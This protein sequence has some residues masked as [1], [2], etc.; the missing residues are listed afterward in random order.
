MVRPTQVKDRDHSSV[1]PPAPF[2]AVR[3]LAAVLVA[4]D[5]LTADV[6]LSPGDPA[7]I[8]ELHAGS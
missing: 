6:A 3:C 4:Y 7:R 5:V 2:G 8:R 1:P